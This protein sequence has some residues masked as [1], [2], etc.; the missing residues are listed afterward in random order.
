MKVKNDK[1]ES[2][3]RSSSQGSRHFLVFA[4]GV[5]YEQ[6]VY[7]TKNHSLL[8][9]NKYTQNLG[10]HTDPVRW[11]VV[12]GRTVHDQ[13][14]LFSGSHGRRPNTVTMPPSVGVYI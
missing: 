7:N 12:R 14:V 1:L 2:F 13:L 3:F 11:A 4:S 9:N 8:K 10:E 6:F 5:K